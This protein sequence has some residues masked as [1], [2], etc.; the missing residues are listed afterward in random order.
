MEHDTL[1]Q[2]LKA[3]SLHTIAARFEEEAQKAS[4]LKLSYS[5]FLANL[6]EEEYLTRTD[7]S[8]A[9][10][11]AKAK[12]PFQRTLEQFDFSF[13]PSLSPQLI[14][15]LAHLSFMEKAEN[16]IFLGP[17]GTG[18]THLSV[19]IGIKAC[20]ARKRVVCYSIENLIEVLVAAKVDGTLPRRLAELSRIDLLVC[21]E[22]GFNA[23]DRDKAHLLFQMIAKRYER[24]SIILTSNKSFEEWGDIFCGDNII[25]SGLLDRLLH[26]SHIVVINGPSYRTRDKLN[27]TKVDKG[28]KLSPENE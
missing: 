5:D 28:K 16:I 7:R 19:A 23:I 21:D 9:A 12:F 15:E 22:L 20:M 26:H 14:K 17:P 11:I 25:A 10:R 24:G 1:K 18:K 3:L 4:K 13:Q 6:V 2:H 8:I 27:K